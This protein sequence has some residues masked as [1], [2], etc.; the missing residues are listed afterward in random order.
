MKRKIL[1][2][3]AVLVSVLMSTAALAACNKAPAEQESGGGS[4]ESLST[5]QG[6]EPSVSE[7]GGNSGAQMGT[8]EESHS[9]SGAQSESFCKRAKELTAQ[10]HGNAVWLENSADI[11][12]TEYGIVLHQTIEVDG[13]V[14][15]C[16]EN[17]T[18]VYDAESGKLRYKAENDDVIRVEAYSE[19][20][21]YDYRLLL[22]DSIVYRSTSDENKILSEALPLGMQ[23][24][25]RDLYDEFRDCY[26]INEQ[27]FTWQDDDGI[28]LL[29]L[30][31]GEPE[32]ILSNEDFSK[33]YENILSDHPADSFPEYMGKMLY[34]C[35]RFICGGTKIVATAFKEGSICTGIVIYNI[36][37]NKIELGH[38]ILEPHE[39]Q[40]PLS[41][42]YIM[43]DWYRI[44]AETDETYKPAGTFKELNGWETADGITAVFC[45]YGLN[46]DG[47]QSDRRNLQLYFREID[48][49]QKY[50]R[51]IASVANPRTEAYFTLLSS[52]YLLIDIDKDIFVVKYSE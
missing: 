25:Q 15:L 19:R 33:N 30:N 46:G 6:G 47:D 35:P 48:H 16:N 40:Y 49:P 12:D 11:Y 31:G 42:R 32:L 34:G 13:A 17:N 39:A 5:E 10:I 20:D 29:K 52:D 7:S 44:D 22:C 50:F 51:H 43:D 3:L 9:E 28:K 1:S 37:E 45:L 26:D 36:S 4:G 41:D 18:F 8:E 23:F 27:Y 38:S 2:V 21:G 24:E 14:I